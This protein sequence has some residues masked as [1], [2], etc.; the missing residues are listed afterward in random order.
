MIKFL[1]KFL[2]FTFLLISTSF[3]EIIKE[4]KISGN[5]RIS[6]ETILV[7]GDISV[8]KNFDKVTLNESLKNL[9][10]TDFFKNINIDL[11]NG[12]LNLEIVEN[13]IIENIE[14]KGVKSKTLKKNISETIVLK[15]RM[16]FTENQL[17]KDINLITNILK[18]NGFY[19][20]KI[21]SSFTK[22]EELNSIRINIDIDQGKKAKIKEIVFIGDK[23][24]KDKKLLEIIASEEHKFWKFISNK[25]YLNQSLI[26]LDTRLL[27][28]FYKNQGY[29]KV[30]VLNSFAELS[31]EGSF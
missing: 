14:I 29:Y 12:I 7:L 23:K 8:G 1:L 18:I 3:G 24:I 27:E 9:Y 10:K 5:K 28:N 4:I 25:V 21:R 2:A 19:F 22:N 6:N 16:S 31:E 15:N 17:K 26:G 20:A 30:R 11:S 13:P